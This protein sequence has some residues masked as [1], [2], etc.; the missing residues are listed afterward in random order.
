MQDE[1]RQDP[2]TAEETARDARLRQRLLLQRQVVACLTSV[3]TVIVV[4][5][6]AGTGYLGFEPAMVYAGIVCTLAAVFYALVRTGINRRFADPSMTMAQTMAAGLAISYGAYFA[7]ESRPLFVALYAVAMSFGLFSLNVRRLVLIGGFQVACFAT[8]VALLAWL[9]PEETR[10]ARELLRLMALSMCVVWLVFMGQYVARLRR[11][12][13]RTDREL[14]ASESRYRALSDLS[15]DAYWEQDAL[16]RFTRLSLTQTGVTSLLAELDWT[17]REPWT[18]PAMELADGDWNEH[19]AVL[20]ERLPFRDLVL[21][22]VGENDEASY[23]SLSGYPVFGKRGDFRGYRGIARD[24]SERRRIEERLSYLAQFDT[25]TGLP[26]RHL[27]HDRLTQHLLRARRSL[28][29]VGC[30][31]VDLDR[32]KNINETYGHSV[33]DDLLVQ[34]AARLQRCLRAGDT[35]GRFG[36]D[37]FA[38]L[39]PDLVRADDA[40]IV[41]GKI[42][43]SLAAP[44]ELAG[45]DTFVTVSIGIATCPD[46][47]DSA[48]RLLGNAEAAMYRAKEAGRNGYQFYLPLMNAQAK[49][50]LRLEASLR[51][52]LERDEFHLEYQPKV[53]LA[54]GA[55]SG[56][57]ALLRWKT[58]QGENIPPNQ[59][60]PVLEDTGLIIPVGELV[61][62]KACRQMRVWHDMG[63]PPRTVAVNVSARQF[64]HNDFRATVQRIVNEAAV[65]PRLLQLELTESLLMLD[66]EQ[67]VKT[68]SALK[69]FGVRLSIDDFGTGFSSLAYLQR[70]PLDELKIDRAFI[71]DAIASHNDATIALAIVNLAHSLHLNVVAEGVETEAQIVFLRK[72]GCD[73]MQGF[74]FSRPAPADTCTAMLRE[75]RM[76]SI[77]A[78]DDVADTPTALVVDSNPVDLLGMQTLL[79]SLRYRVFTAA[80]AEAG[81]AILAR[82]TIHVVVTE[83]GGI[84]EGSLTGGIHFLASVRRLYPQAVRIAIGNVD[85][86]GHAE[87]LAAAINKAGIHK[88]LSKSWDASRLRAEVREALPGAQRNVA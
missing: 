36:G 88:Y 4:L 81:Y 5:A 19:R 16:H 45:R 53:D 48:D 72:H 59:F 83:H 3:M 86:A 29:R 11:T 61:L 65:D 85:S 39:L 54:S 82:H 15:A 7:S 69:I 66:P 20:A 34:M 17:G 78:N 52:A 38:V 58:A 57:E 51:G 74:Y 47:G 80:T 30:M 87:V 26:N 64:Q 40:G 62:E 25:L 60:I 9:R 24:I 56:F 2:P 6:A 35:F 63:L 32:F 49:E 8:V 37:K 12:I 71:R 23:L 43:G 50:R 18:L 42:L 21:K 22:H 27:L 77:P 76:L 28:G 79:A 33:G 68:L 44:F 10:L 31:F 84:G 1:R 73:Q 13:T 75:D 46:D 14:E 70:F 55:I 67:A 41:A